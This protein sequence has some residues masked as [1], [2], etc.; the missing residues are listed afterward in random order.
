MQEHQMTEIEPTTFF[1]EKE[2]LPAAL[3]S[4]GNIVECN[5]LFT[6]MLQLSESELIGVPLENLNAKYVAGDGAISTMPLNLNAAHPPQ[7]VFLTSKQPAL[8]CAEMTVKEMVCDGKS[9]Q[10]VTFLRLSSELQ[11]A[12]S[13]ELKRAEVALRLWHVAIFDHDHVRNNIYISNMFKQIHGVEYDEEMTFQTAGSFIHPDDKNLDVVLRAHDPAGD[14]LFDMSFRIVL[15]NGDTRWVRSRSQ[16]EFGEIDGKLGSIRTLGA[17][18]DFTDEHLLKTSLKDHKQRLSDI[19]DSLPSIVLGVDQNGYIT[20]WNKLADSQF[21]ISDAAPEN[22]KLEEMCP[23]LLSEMPRI[24][25][26]MR[27]RSALELNR[28]PYIRD[29]ISIFYNVSITSLHNS[30]EYDVVVRIDDVSEQVRIEQMMVQSEKL[31]SVGGLAAGMAHEINNPLAAVMQN[32]Q[33]LKMRLDPEMEAN[34]SAAERN[35]T[36]IEKIRGYLAE[37]KI[38]R[39]VDAISDATGRAASIVSNMLGFVRINTD[40]KN[41]CHMMELIDTAL[42][43]ALNDYDLRKKYDFRKIE[44]V[45]ESDAEELEVFCDPA[46]MQQVLLNLIKNAGQA[47]VTAGVPSPRIVIRL[48]RGDG[49][50]RIELEDNGPGVPDAIASR[51]FEPFFTTK[52]VGEGTGLGLSISYSIVVKEHNGKMHLERGAAGGAKFVIELPLR[53]PLNDGLTEYVA[54]R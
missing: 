43:L 12:Q 35:G 41:M 53:D 33:V 32:A 49:C 23:M 11:Q 14:G 7:T 29:H 40:K 17:M 52:P 37:R 2:V 26:A 30:S 20:Q 54:D 38:F 31:L 1:I 47:L 22:R 3:I 15:R 6:E 24:R 44:I 39:M 51:V 21:G 50:T 16:T 10:M 9:M 18:V 19:L 4:E 42:E 45:R 25:E 36:T 28:V 13:N 5:R 8:L 48:K 27:T 34:R 46:K